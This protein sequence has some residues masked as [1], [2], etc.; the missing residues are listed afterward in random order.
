MGWDKAA[1]LVVDERIVFEKM[2][3]FIPVEIAEYEVISGEIDGYEA[4][5]DSR[6]IFNKG[7]RES[8][9]FHG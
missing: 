7:K 5:V 2:G 3:N 4:I 9:V 8:E 6:F 1:E